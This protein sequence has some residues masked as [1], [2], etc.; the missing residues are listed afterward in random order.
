VNFDNIIF[1]LAV[2]FAGASLLATLFLWLK[3][4]VVLAYIFWGMLVGPAGLSL[5][6][7]PAHIEHLSHFGVV[8]LLF[9]LGLHLH[10]KRLLESFAKTSLVTFGTC[11]LFAAL[12]AGVPWAFGFGGMDCLV[13]GACVMFSSTAVGLMLLPLSKV[14]RRHLRAMMSGVLLMQDIIAVVLMLLFTSDRGSALWQLFPSLLVRTCL[15]VAGAFL[16]VRFVIVPLL[17]RFA[18]PKEYAFVLS[19]GWCLALAYVGSRLGLSYEI[20]ALIAGLS[21]A[22][23][24]ESVGLTEPLVPLREF[25][26]VLYFFAIGAMFDYTL[27][28]HVWLPGLVLA[29][30]LLVAKPLAFRFGFRHTGEKDA[31][32]QELGIRLGQAS[33][34]SLLLAG[35]ALAADD[36]SLRAAYLVQFVTVVTFVVSTYVTVLRYPTSP[37]SQEATGKAPAS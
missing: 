31:L 24:P 7:D 29:A 28:A 18:E 19:L 35:T 10:P 11:A 14:R 3:Q 23:S 15:L 2:I 22:P 16:A 5:I 34:F 1:E 27:T 12:G 25:F 4:P 37:G 32:A 6:E 8:L 13:I 21:L 20:G 9:L 17:M 33:E 36:M 30:L 26:L